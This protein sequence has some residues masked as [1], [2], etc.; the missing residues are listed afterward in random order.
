LSIAFTLAVFHWPERHRSRHCSRLSQ[1][2]CIIQPHES[3]SEP[4][5]SHMKSNTSTVDEIGVVEH[6]LAADD[7]GVVA[8]PERPLR[9]AAA[10]GVLLAPQDLADP[11]P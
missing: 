8:G 1:V 5:G 7:A 11:I 4:N 10:R 6:E 2:R 9:G 3:T